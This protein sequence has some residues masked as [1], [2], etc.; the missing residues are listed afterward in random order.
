MMTVNYDVIIG[1][2]LNAKHESILELFSELFAHLLHNFTNLHGFKICVILKFIYGL[3]RV[4][5]FFS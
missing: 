5:Y 3:E 4:K 1:T 2:T